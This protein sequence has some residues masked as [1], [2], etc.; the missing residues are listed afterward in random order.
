M[1]VRRSYPKRDDLP[2]EEREFY[3]ERWFPTRTDTVPD[4]LP[5]GTGEL[6]RVKVGMGMTMNLGDY[7]SARVDVGLELPCRPAEVKEAFGL[8]WETVESEIRVQIRE[9]RAGKDFAEKQK[10]RKKG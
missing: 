5:P 9:T 6:A 10:N 8:A 2:P 1:W 7:Q 4:V 3:E